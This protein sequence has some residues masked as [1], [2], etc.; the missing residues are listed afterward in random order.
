MI[1]YLPTDYP[2]L[3]C[4]KVNR[5]VDR[6]ERKYHLKINDGWKLFQ[7]YA[8]QFSFETKTL[9]VR[10]KDTDIHTLTNEEL[11]IVV[12]QVTEELESRKAC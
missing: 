10:T 5:A 11:E 9:G 2:K 4:N 3:N 6:I 12:K 8:E 7:K 1:D